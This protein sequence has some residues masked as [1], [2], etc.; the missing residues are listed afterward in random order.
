MAK[1]QLTIEEKLQAALVPVEEQ[2]YKVPE[3][4]CWV[5]FDVTAELKKGPF[6]S[7][8]TKAMFVPKGKDTYKV[9]EQ[10]NAIRKTTQYGSYYITEAKYQELKNFAINDGDIIVSCAGTVG[11]LYKLPSDCEAG[12]INQAL[13]RVRV[14]NIVNEFY[15]INYFSGIMLQ[16]VV[17]SSQ[18]T[19]IKNIPPFKVLKSM[20][21]PMPPQREQSRIVARIESLFAKLD[22]AKEKIQE[23]L[24]G[25]DLR[26]AAILHQAFTGK[27]TEKWRKE[28]NISIA[29]W[30]EKTLK[31]CCRIGSGGTPSRKYPAFY[32]GDIPWVKTGEINWNELYDTEEHISKEA[33]DNSSAKLYRDGA[34]LVAMYGMGATRGRAAI[35]RTNATTNQAVCALETK[36]NLLNQFLFYYFMNNYWKIREKAVGGNQLN[37]SG[38]II[39]KLEVKLPVIE[40]QQEIVRL[41]DNLL[42][43]EQSTVTACEEALTIIDTLKKSILARAF[44]GEL[45]TNDPADPSAQ[46][47]LQEILEA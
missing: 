35:L 21:F 43:R 28:K 45:A 38:K 36:E 20:P 9:Y 46:G 39:E 44:R 4:W 26:R 15:F 10:G 18:G 24:D 14:S 22:E 11:E 40:E 7:S 2:P 8:L 1:K 12:V 37:L 3:N 17:N 41:L 27:L 30:K 42:S 13:M 6:G 19:A 23:V 16:D 34:V 32:R 5:R 29:D 25:A 47:L 31:D 33:I